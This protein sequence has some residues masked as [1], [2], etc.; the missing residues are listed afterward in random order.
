MAYYM[1]QPYLI[2]RVPVVPQVPIVPQQF[3][4]QQQA[5]YQKQPDPVL[6]EKLQEKGLLENC[7]LQSVS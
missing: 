2:G 7:L 6:E 1:G 5:V 3:S 4:S